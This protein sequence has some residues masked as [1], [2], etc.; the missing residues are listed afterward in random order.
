MN[1]E[2][3]KRYKERLVALRARLRGD[4]SQMTDVTLDKALRRA[5]GAPSAMPIHMADVGENFEREFT[6]GLLENKDRTLAQITEALDRIEDGVYGRC[7][8]CDTKI[9]KTRLNAIP[10]AILCVE[11]ASRPE[12]SSFLP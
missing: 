11:C 1:T 12:C 4:L 8:D 7:A 6:L 3:S 2:D 10:Y 9:P 5:G